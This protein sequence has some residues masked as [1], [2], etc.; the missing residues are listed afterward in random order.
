MVAAQASTAGITLTP[1]GRTSSDWVDAVGGEVEGSELAHLAGPNDE[2]APVRYDD[3]LI[4]AEIAD[5]SGAVSVVAEDGAIVSD[6]ECINRRSVCGACRQ[7]IGNIDRG[8]L[9]G[10]CDVESA[11]ALFEEIARALVEFLRREVI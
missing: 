2:N 8:D 9:V 1:T 7:I 4:I 3:V 5:E 6:G 11:T 10:Q